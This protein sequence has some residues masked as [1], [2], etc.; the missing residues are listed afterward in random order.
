[1]QV[2]AACCGVIAGSVINPGIHSRQNAAGPIKQ[3]DKPLR[4]QLRRCTQLPRGELC[5]L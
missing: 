2:G 5:R 3:E 1:M 4:G